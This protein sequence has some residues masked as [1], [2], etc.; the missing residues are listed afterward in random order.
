MGEWKYWNQ[1]KRRSGKRKAWK[2]ITAPL[3]VIASVCRP[4]NPFFCSEMAVCGGEGSIVGGTTCQF[5]QRRPNSTCC[6]IWWKIHILSKHH[7]TLYFQQKIYKSSIIIMKAMICDCR[8]IYNILYWYIV[9]F[10]VSKYL[11]ILLW[12]S[13]KIKAFEAVTITVDNNNRHV[14]ARIYRF[15]KHWEIQTC[16]HLF[17]WGNTCFITAETFITYK[18]L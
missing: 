10:I 8:Y 18:W 14:T 6:K 13:H 12:P 16:V 7:S 5:C 15:W 2:N 1:T 9:E 11:V 4:F 3:S 17:S